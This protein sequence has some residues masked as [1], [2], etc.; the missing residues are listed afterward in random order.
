M[1]GTIELKWYRVVLM[2][3]AFTMLE[4]I[5]VIVIL[6]I[7]ASV[8]IPKL[9]A[10]RDDAKIVSKTNEIR[11]ILSE[12]SASYFATGKVEALQNMSQVL[13]QLV[14]QNK[15]RVTSVNPINNSVGQLTIYTQNGASEDS[16]FILD[17]NGTTLSIKHGVPCSGAICKELQVRVSEG[18][19]S[20]G[21]ERVN[22]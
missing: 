19:Y 16:A 3:D 22:F 13:K 9:A 21:G 17:L 10:T 12:I 15:A 14:L 18:N 11:S 1:V 4:L 7:L 5:F 8:A 20:I 2:R 6:G